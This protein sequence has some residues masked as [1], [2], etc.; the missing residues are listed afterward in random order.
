MKIFE[1]KQ[2]SINN[3]G[4]SGNMR[5]NDEVIRR[6]LYTLPASCTTARC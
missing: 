1:G 3:V 6:E 2:F 5:V 4:I